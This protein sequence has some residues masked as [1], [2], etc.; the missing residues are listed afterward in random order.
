LT[1][2]GIKRWNAEEQSAMTTHLDKSHLMDG[3]EECAIDPSESLDA[4]QQ[5]VQ[6]FVQ[7]FESRGTWGNLLAGNVGLNWINLPSPAMTIRHH[8]ILS[9]AFSCF[10]GGFLS[11]GEIDWGLP[12]DYI[13]H[14]VAQ[15]TANA[16]F[17]LDQIKRGKLGEE[18]NFQLEWLDGNLL[19]L[20]YFPCQ[21]T[22]YISPGPWKIT[23][24]LSL[25]QLLCLSY[26]TVKT[27]LVQRSLNEHEDLNSIL[28]VQNGAN[29]EQTGLLVPLSPS[30][31]VFHQLSKKPEL[32][33]ISALS[34]SREQAQVDN[35]LNNHLVMFP[36]LA[37]AQQFT[38]DQDC[39]FE[40]SWLS[41]AEESNLQST[42]TK[43][44]NSS[45]TNLES[46]NL[47]SPCI[48]STGDFTASFQGTCFHVI[49]ARG[50]PYNLLLDHFPS[51]REK[52]CTLSD[53][54][55]G[56]EWH[57]YIKSYLTTPTALA[58]KFKTEVRSVAAQ[59][60]AALKST[61]ST[62]E[63]TF[64]AENATE[65]DLNGWLQQCWANECI[66]QV[67][68]SLEYLRNVR[69]NN[70]EYEH[71]LLM[72][73]L[74]SYIT[75][76]DIWSSSSAV[77]FPLRIVDENSSRANPTNALRLWFEQACLAYFH[78]DI[79]DIIGPL[80]IMCGGSKEDFLQSPTFLSP[81]LAKMK[82]RVISS[83]NDSLV[84]PSGRVLKDRLR[85]MKEVFLSKTT[86][87]NQSKRSNSLA[88]IMNNS[89]GHRTAPS[90]AEVSQ[91]RTPKKKR[92]FFDDSDDERIDH[93]SPTAHKSNHT[94]VGNKVIKTNIPFFVRRHTL[95]GA[96]DFAARLRGTNSPPSPDP[97]GSP[98]RGR[99]SNSS[100][101]DVGE[102][103]QTYS[104]SKPRRTLSFQTH[105]GQDSL[106]PDAPEN[107]TSRKGSQPGESKVQLKNVKRRGGIQSLFNRYQKS[108]RE[109]LSE[110]VTP[111]CASSVE[112]VEI[113]N[114]P[115]SPRIR[116]APPK[117]APSV[118]ST[119]QNKVLHGI[120]LHG[121]ASVKRSAQKAGLSELLSPFRALN[122]V[123]REIEEDQE[124][125]NDSLS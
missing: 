106:I 63:I 53:G 31:R 75:K 88:P 10:G 117:L 100:P 57:D 5:E 95:H 80:Y 112:S 103:S 21:G 98:C 44:L 41:D 107:L 92:L 66:L 64:I 84:A 110:E 42:P 79:P 7:S 36:S 54:V 51:L 26:V 14:P 70:I 65:R 69:E 115:Q 18:K 12:L 59:D 8:A 19:N 1:V 55:P 73:N 52:W 48:Y 49:Y 119:P 67:I 78:A 11:L 17:L 33:G 22:N 34:E 16:P 87:P 97:P 101:S 37:Q 111:S 91:Q 99:G 58:K 76:L 62:I 120:A 28:V 29:S 50:C 118:P 6:K 61:L 124:N 96:L 23:N 3:L 82:A 47:R 123:V 86:A 15:P 90:S 121:S 125:I 4:W 108:S 104:I 35:Q 56:S 116:E 30:F 74:E 39:T 27:V 71:E 60:R 24:V 38:S 13:F 81:K 25:E 122:D 83:K 68:L 105:K 2:E 46:V 85:G 109:E 102:S 20:I 77:E 43:C 40:I 45:Q 72:G 89:I 93:C 9:R 32:A 94:L 114:I 113:R